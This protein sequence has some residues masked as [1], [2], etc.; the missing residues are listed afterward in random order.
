MHI[1]ENDLSWREPI[2]IMP[3]NQAFPDMSALAGLSAEFRRYEER[4]VVLN[5][6]HSRLFG[7][8][9][10]KAVV[11]PHL[12]L[13]NILSDTYERLYD[14]EGVMNINSV[15]NGAKITITMELPLEEP[16]DVGNGD[17]H[18]LLLLAQNGYT[19]GESPKIRM[20]VMRLICLNGAVIGKQIAC[21]P[22]REMMDGFSTKTLAAKV[23]RLVDHSRKVT[24]VWQ[25]WM[26]IQIPRL[27]ASPL[28]E[29]HFPSKFVEPILEDEVFPMSKYDLYNMMT[30]RAT[31]DVASDLSRMVI[32]NRIA[33]VFYGNAFEKATKMVEME[34]AQPL[35]I[36]DAD[37]SATRTETDEI[38]H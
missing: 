24:D 21:I 2:E 26:G 23:N 5:E 34:L 13:V 6:D 25:S 33:T 32:D 36:V 11:L 30:R 22:A 37:I 27:A 38:S 31:H 19:N 1:V 4:K 15:N 10:K 14:Q 29:N 8:F 18:N 7:V 12:D 3:L 9:G 20:G 35:V 28:F 17:K 16:L